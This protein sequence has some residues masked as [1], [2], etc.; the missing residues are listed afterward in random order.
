MQASDVFTQEISAQLPSL[1]RSQPSV[2]FIL[3]WISRVVIVVEIGLVVFGLFGVQ[4]VLLQLCNSCW[5]MSF[6]FTLIGLMIVLMLGQYYLN[7]TQSKFIERWTMVSSIIV[8]VL[9]AGVIAC[10]LT[11]PIMVSVS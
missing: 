2:H 1:D 7:Q 6:L 8:T 9:G 10:I 5:Q 11:T 3:P 4:Q